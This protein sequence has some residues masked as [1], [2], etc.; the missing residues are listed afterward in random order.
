M[1]KQTLKTKIINHLK[2]VDPDKSAMGLVIRN[3]IQKEINFENV[4]AFIKDQYADNKEGMIRVIGSVPMLL[5]LQ[6]HK[7][8]TV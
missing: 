4:V 6:Y 8:K 5:I 2:E 7:L 1:D 3:A